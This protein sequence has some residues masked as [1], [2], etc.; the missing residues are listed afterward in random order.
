[1]V[2]KSNIS[3]DTVQTNI[4]AKTR[5][6]LRT[7]GQTRRKVT[8]GG[9]PV[10][11][12]TDAASAVLAPI[13]NSLQATKAS[14]QHNLTYGEIEWPTLKFIVDYVEK[15][16]FNANS[17]KGRFYDLG[18]GRGRAVLY[19]ALA[20]P[21]EQSVGIE[22]LPERVTLAQQALTALKNSIPSAGAKVRLYEASFMNPA[23]KYR[24]ARAIYLSNLAFDNETQDAIFKKLTVEMPKGSL[25]FCHKPPVP[26]P[27]AFELLAV[28]RMPMS[29]TPTSDF[30]ILRHI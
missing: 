18:C 17:S 6:F 19:M 29:W 27:A 20:G 7:R 4:Q 21:F 24:D 30:H 16:P 1:M 10:K 5:R 14:G 23:F 9:G 22:V 26:I 13:Y 2:N 28:E 8:L 12:N 25:L 15:T 11:L 3:M